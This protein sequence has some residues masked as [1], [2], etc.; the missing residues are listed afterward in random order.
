MSSLVVDMESLQTKHSEVSAM[1]TQKEA[2]LSQA[3]TV[4]SK[5]KSAELCV[6][7]AT[8]S[9]FRPLI[10]CDVPARMH[11]CMLVIMFV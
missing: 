11:G 7:I 8:Y 6:Y 10:L 3:L 1:L 2:E 4:L 5:K 9:L